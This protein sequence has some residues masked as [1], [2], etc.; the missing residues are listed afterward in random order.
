LLLL[1]LLKL[2]TRDRRKGELLRI[3]LSACTEDGIEFR[4]NKNPDDL[5]PIEWTPQLK[6]II[7]EI[8]SLPPRRIG[9]AYIIHQQAW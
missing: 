3:K 7:H 8:E 1:I 4:N 5:H 2:C 6:S 9:S